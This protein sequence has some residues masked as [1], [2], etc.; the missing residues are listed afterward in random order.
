MRVAHSAIRHRIAVGDD[1]HFL[2]VGQIRERYGAPDSWI[3]RRTADANFPK[4]VRFGSGAL[5][6]RRPKMAEFFAIHRR[7]A[8]FPDPVIAHAFIPKAHVFY[9]DNGR[10]EAEVVLDPRRLRKLTIEPF[11]QVKS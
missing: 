10:N 7:G 8:S 3:A 6:V 1:A 4:P 2:T 5:A 9:A 11:V